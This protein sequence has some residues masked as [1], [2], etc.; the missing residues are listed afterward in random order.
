MGNKMREQLFSSS[1]KRS[2]QTY[3]AVEV[4][5]SHASKCPVHDPLSQVQ[6]LDMKTYLV[7]DILT[8]VD[9]ASMAHSLEVRV[10]LLDHKLVEWISS[11]PPS[12]KLHGKEGKFVLKKALETYLPDDI[13]YRDKMGFAVPLASWFRGPLRQKLHKALMGPTLADTGIF[14][15]SFLEKMLDQH[16][17]GKRDYSAPLW[18]LL[19]F[20]SFLRNMD[21]QK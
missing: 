7:G 17:S 13:L 3:Q 4:L 20:E 21:P 14:N 1:F 18:T 2:L 6:Y 16:Q 5:R 10:P 19:M 15:Q 11:I 8:K 12:L 9:R